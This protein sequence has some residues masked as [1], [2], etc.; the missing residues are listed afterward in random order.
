MLEEAKMKRHDL[1][2]PVHKALRA[3]LAQLMV[4]LGQTDFTDE[5]EGTTAIA[6]VRRQLAASASH[7]AHEETH[8]HTA[9][10][11]RDPGSS[12]AL[13]VDHKHHRAAFFDMEVLLERIE[14]T[15]VADRASLGRILYLRFSKLVADDLA[16]M[17]EEELETLVR[18]HELFSDDELR[19]IEADIIASLPPQER[20][21]TLG[22]F[23][24]VMNRPERI[25]FLSFARASA[26]P[27]AFNA[28]M[29]ATVRP[30]LKP[31]DW[32]HLSEGLKLAA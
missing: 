6:L 15:P 13:E 10:E 11:A 26:P 18:L 22:R 1:Y 9:L 23:V 17:A 24:P 29:E 8:V 4:K 25:H 7:L 3:S 30:A 28:L 2:G 21:E 14:D 20:M 31:E 32:R 12:T 16:H 5:A 27:E 19:A